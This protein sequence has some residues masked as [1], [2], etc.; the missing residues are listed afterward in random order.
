MGPSLARLRFC[1]AI[2]LG[3]VAR[4]RHQGLLLAIP[5]HRPPAKI[6]AARELRHTAGVFV[7]SPDGREPLD[8]AVSAA[9]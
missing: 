3:A 7:G 9:I 1:L 6:A 4:A 2:D 5:V 8:A